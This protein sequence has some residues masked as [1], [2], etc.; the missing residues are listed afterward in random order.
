VDGI[1][2]NCCNK[3]YDEPGQKVKTGCIQCSADK[4]K[5]WKMSE[6]VYAGLQK[7]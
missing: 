5:C 3:E 4:V 1:D 2:K 7:L 6:E